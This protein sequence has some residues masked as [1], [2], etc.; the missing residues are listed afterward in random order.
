[1]AGEKEKKETE[2]SD[3]RFRNEEKRRTLHAIESQVERERRKV[4]PNPSNF[5]IDL[6]R[7]LEKRVS[8]RY[9]KDQK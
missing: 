5:S 6:F 9:S 3:N 8:I 2:L 4:M 1:M 7:L